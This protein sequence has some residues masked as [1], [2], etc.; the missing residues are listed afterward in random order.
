MA[1]QLV[2][3]FLPRGF[4]SASVHVGFVVRQVALEEVFP[5][6]LQFSPVSYYSTVAINT[7]TLPGGRI[8]RPPEVTVQRHCLTPSV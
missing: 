6:V 8:I 5:R 2:A 3:V 7:H 1:K 4:S